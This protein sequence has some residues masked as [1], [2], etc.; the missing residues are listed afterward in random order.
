MI[1]PEIRSLMA[2]A[3]NVL[4]HPVHWY[5]EEA[6]QKSRR[7]LAIQI[8]T[9]L[10]KARPKRPRVPAVEQDTWSP[11]LLWGIFVAGVLTG[12]AVVLAIA[13]HLK[14]LTP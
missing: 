9:A 4:S 6:H 14:G 3:R 13:P 5:S 7:E 8:N 2:R 10:N 12:A 1:A 11:P